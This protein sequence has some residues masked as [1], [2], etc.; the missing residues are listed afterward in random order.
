MPFLPTA[1]SVVSDEILW[2][3]DCVERNGAERRPLETVLIQNTG[4]VS[5][6]LTPGSPQ[7][8]KELRSAISVERSEE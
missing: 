1:A 2:S 5:P 4:W 6:R 7:S 8:L 3:N